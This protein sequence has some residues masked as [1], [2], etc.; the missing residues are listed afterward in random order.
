VISA[1][2][3]PASAGEADHAMHLCERLGELALDVHVLTQKIKGPGSRSYTVHASMPDWGWPDLPR[4]AHRLKA[5]SPDAVLLLYTPRDYNHRDMITYAPSIAKRIVPRA[6]FVTQ[7]ETALMGPQGSRFVRA[8]RKGVAA[9]VGQK[10]LDYVFGTLLCKSDHVITLSEKHSTALTRHFPQLNGKV[11]VIPPPPLLRMCAKKETARERGRGRLGA[12]PDD[13][14]LAYYGY[15]YEE[16]G[17]ETLI[18]ALSLLKNRRRSR[19]VIIG[20]N[21]GESHGGSYLERLK[22][23][24]QNLGVSDRIVWTGEYN[25]GSEQ[26]SVYLHAADACVFPFKYGVSLNR[27]SVAAGAAHGLPIVTT[28]GADLERAFVD[29]ENVL[30]CPPEDPPA[31]AAALDSVMADP[32]LYRALA[33]GARELARRHFSWEGALKKTV[34][35]LGG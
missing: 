6:R 9:C 35:A 19:L 18:T 26:A 2:F 28:R 14:L 13:F 15:V 25:S 5:C 7:F 3:P 32:D 8:V 34:E 17:I 33:A 11:S 27:S 31:L 24:A 21:P 1:A 29:Q 22:A 4:F 23:G 10:K 20:G 30:L 16:K 12:K